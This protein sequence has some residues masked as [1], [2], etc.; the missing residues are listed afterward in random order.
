MQQLLVTLIFLSAV[1][2]LGW[3][4][5]VSL[6]RPAQGGCGKGCGCE[7]PKGSVSVEK[8]SKNRLTKDYFG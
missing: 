1:G 3:R 4:V 5:W 7:E 2:Y 6:R 8:Q